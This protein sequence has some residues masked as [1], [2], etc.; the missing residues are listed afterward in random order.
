MGS[1]SARVI[2]AW[3]FLLWSGGGLPL[4]FGP[5]AAEEDCDRARQAAWSVVPEQGRPSVRCF[6]LPPTAFPQQFNFEE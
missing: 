3:W 5:F 1:R 6:E 4:I 2:V